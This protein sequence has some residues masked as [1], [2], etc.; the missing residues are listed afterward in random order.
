[1]AHTVEV[2]IKNH[3]L[4]REEAGVDFTVEDGNGKFGELLVSKGG[5]RWKPKGVR[6]HHFVSW[7]DFDDFMRGRQKR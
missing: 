2:N 7:K 6:D 5:I 4:S 3:P 1:M